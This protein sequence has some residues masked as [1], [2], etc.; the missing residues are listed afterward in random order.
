MFRRDILPPLSRSESAPNKI[1]R[2]HG[3]ISQKIEL[4]IVT[5]VRSSNPTI[6]YTLLCFGDPAFPL[7]YSD[8][9][10]CGA[11]DR[12]C[13]RQ[14]DRLKRDVVYWIRLKDTKKGNVFVFIG[15]LDTD[16]LPLWKSAVPCILVPSNYH[17]NTVK[18]SRQSPTSFHS[19]ISWPTFSLI[20]LPRF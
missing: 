10:N 16:L 3:V 8:C 13:L 14:R 15:R 18:F 4:V 17:P 12:A 20:P 5:A 2:L 7:V 9:F 6:E 1:T 11:V 19:C